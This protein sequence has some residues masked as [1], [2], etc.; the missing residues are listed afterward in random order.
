MLAA[1]W[2]AV[3]TSTARKSAAGRRRAWSMAG[4]DSLWRLP[5]ITQ[6]WV[7]YCRARSRAE[8][9]TQAAHIGARV[10]SEARGGLS[11]HGSELG[12][13]ATG[14]GYGSPP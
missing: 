4:M 8:Q 14:L 5:V 9:P 11:A 1:I 10:V 2:T 6:L 7:A 3:S 12:C 13:S